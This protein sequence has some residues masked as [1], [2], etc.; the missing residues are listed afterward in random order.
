MGA[1]IDRTGQRFGR[2][3]VLGVE[4]RDRWGK[5]LWLCQC[6][7]GRTISARASNLKAKTSSCGCRRREVAAAL[8]T[9]HGLRGTRTYRIWGNMKTRVTNPNFKDAELYSGRGIDCDPRWLA[10]FEAF[11]A[12]MGECPSDKHSL[13]RWPDNDRG[14]WPDNCRWATDIEQAN[15]RRPRRSRE[16][17]P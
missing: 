2:L 5:L 8:K 12:D 9:S 7:C 1:F 4:G 13:D 16:T 3:V 14:Y 6:D 11:L 15:N 10:S 17:R